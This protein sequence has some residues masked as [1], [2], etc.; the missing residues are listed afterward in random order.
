MQTGTA[1]GTDAL[2]C[3]AMRD[4]GLGP[5]EGCGHA[6]RPRGAAFMRPY[7]K[8][9]GSGGIGRDREGSGGIWRDLEGSGGRSAPPA[10][11]LGRVVYA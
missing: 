9:R 10:R 4:A 3:P 11:L 1:R 6:G 2:L 5:A 7:P 8:R